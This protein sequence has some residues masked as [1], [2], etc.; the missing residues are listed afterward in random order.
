MF[1]YVIARL[2]EPSTHAGIAMLLAAAAAF[3][4]QYAQYIWTVA[5]LFGFGAIATP[6]AKN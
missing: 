5:G 3:V 4:P 1:D 6:E 2:K